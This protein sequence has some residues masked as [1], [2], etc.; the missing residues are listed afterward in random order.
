LQFEEILLYH[1]A[2]VVVN[3]ERERQIDR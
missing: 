3:I 1:F 2:E